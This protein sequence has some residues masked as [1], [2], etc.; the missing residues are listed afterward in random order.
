MNHAAQFRALGALVA[1]LLCLATA[2]ESTAATGRDCV[3]SPQDQ[4]WVERAVVAWELTSREITSI[5]RVPK[6]DALFFDA[7]CV[8]RSSTAMTGGPNRWASSAHDGQVLLPNG[9]TMPAQVTSFT[10]ADGGNAFFV[11]STPSVWRAGG[12]DGGP[13]GLELVMTAVLLHEATHVSQAPSYG[14]SVSELIEKHSLPKDFNDDSIQ[15]RFD[16]DGEFAGSVERETDLLFHA[17]AAADP[18]E[19][20]RLAR[21]ARALMRARH[22]R[23]FAGS[24]AH[25]AAAEDIWL[26][27]EG[28]GQWAAFQW[29]KSPNG[30]AVAETMA[31]EAFGKRGKW[32]SQ[33]Q[34]LAL[35]LALDRLSGDRWKQPVFCTGSRTA[36]QLLDEA[37][38]GS[39]S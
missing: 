23:W 12:V 21:Q 6:L 35:F 16:K 17:A 26:T 25:L 39:P 7:D 36:L 31:L 11:M 28:S 29:L 32:W 19:A 22:S 34:G 15:D 24:D 33:K 37:L 8:I 18:A 3:L 5:G 27:M 38:A 10:S 1:A 4:S 30:G 2:E 14:R 9:T 20:L 13:L